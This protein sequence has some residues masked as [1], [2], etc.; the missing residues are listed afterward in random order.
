MKKKEQVEAIKICH[1]CGAGYPENEKLCPYCGAENGELAQKKFEQEIDEQNQAIEFEKSKPKRFVKAF[2]KKTVI[3]VAVCLLIIVI[4]VPLSIFRETGSNTYEISEE[5]MDELE[6]ALAEGDYETIQTIV[7][8]HN[9]YKGKY[10]GY[11]NLADVYAEHARADK[12][13]KE[14]ENTM[15]EQVFFEEETRTMSVS[16]SV[17]WSI[18]Y[19]LREILF[20]DEILAKNTNYGTEEDIEKLKGMML[21]RFAS[22]G[23]TQDDIVALTEEMET[24]HDAIAH[25]NSLIWN[26]AVEIV[27]KGLL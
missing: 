19:G 16:I 9:L 20:A 21:E 24:D 17:A 8:D 6:Q 27:E 11:A 3:I 23:I 1:N 13:L 2:K 22:W 7:F 10:G 12:S 25:E 15:N 18:H 4:L 5:Y 26:K 14:A